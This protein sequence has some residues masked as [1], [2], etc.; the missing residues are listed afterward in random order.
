LTVHVRDVAGGGTP[1]GR[2]PRLKAR[3]DATP[4]GFAQAKMQVASDLRPYD[5]MH[6]LA[7][8]S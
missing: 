4:V 3:V 1:A 8:A 6:I 5:A 2:I 7:L